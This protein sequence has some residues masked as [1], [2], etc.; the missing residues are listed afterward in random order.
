MNLEGMSFSRERNLDSSIVGGY[1]RSEG[2]CYIYF[3]R[4]TWRQ[5]I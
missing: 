2:R 4:R 5:Q 1:Q 3:Q